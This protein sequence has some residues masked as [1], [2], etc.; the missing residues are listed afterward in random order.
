MKNDLPPDFLQHP[1]KPPRNIPQEL[2]R[3]CQAAC[4]CL[5]VLHFLILP[6]DS[7]RD[8]SKDEW[9][10]LVKNMENSLVPFLCIHERLISY[11]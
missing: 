3:S 8:I 5:L 2:P 1:L 9:K 7:R 6:D 4:D 10:N 11:I